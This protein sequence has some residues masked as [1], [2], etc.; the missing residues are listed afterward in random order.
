VKSPKVE[1]T[2]CA[3]KYK[4]IFCKLEEA[5]LTDISEHKVMNNFKRGQVLFHEGNPAFGAYCISN[6]KIKLTKL[7]EN[8]KETLIHIAGPGDIVGFQHMLQAGSNDVTATALE[9]SQVCFLDRQFLQKLVKEENSCAME[10]LGHV[11]RDMTALQ[12]RMTGIQ[13]RSVRER[14]EFLLIELGSRFGTD[15]SEGVRL[16]VQLSRDEMASMLGMATE[17]LIREISMLKE[18]KF[19]KQDGKTIILLNKK[20]LQIHA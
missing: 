19:L 15:D 9:E 11:A 8:G 17:T 6:G 1:C 16:N 7:S 14:V 12:E 10:L 3:N 13:S 18:E 5:A 2:N 20:N 4:S